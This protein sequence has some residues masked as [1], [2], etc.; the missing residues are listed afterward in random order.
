MDKFCPVLFIYDFSWC[1]GN[2]YTLK[3][4]AEFSLV[5][6]T[7]LFTPWSAEDLDLALEILYCWITSWQLPAAGISQTVFFL[8]PSFPAH[9]SLLS[10][11]GELLERR[12]EQ[13]PLQRDGGS[14]GCCFPWGQQVSNMRDGSPSSCPGS[15]SSFTSSWAF[16]HLCGS[17]KVQQLPPRTQ[18]PRWVVCPCFSETCLRYLPI[19]GELLP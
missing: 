19:A 9:A 2:R 17:L 16:L 14:H 11:V 7:A 5:L 15:C 12:D 3:P 13:Q 8:C 1:E 6:E 4:M 10:A 18:K